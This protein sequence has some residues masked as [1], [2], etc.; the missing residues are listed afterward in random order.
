[1][2]IYNT[3]EPAYDVS[4]GDANFDSIPFEGKTFIGV[5]FFYTSISQ[6]DATF[7]LQESLDGVNFID[8]QDSSGS[9]IELTINNTISTD[10]LKA[11][12]F[13][14]GYIRIR[15]IEGTAATG[16]VNKIKFLFE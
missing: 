4:G 14:T 3:L 9:D 12:D 1:M 11:F 8:S 5:Q 10:I 6:A 13:N 16:T 7:R 15:Y 2:K